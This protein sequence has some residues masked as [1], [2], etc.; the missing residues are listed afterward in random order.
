MSQYANTQ[1]LPHE[2]SP[3]QQ[4]P[5]TKQI[6]LPH[7]S[8][9]QLLCSLHASLDLKTVIRHFAQSVKQHL[10]C[11]CVYYANDEIVKVIQ[12]GTVRHYR[13]SY[14][15]SLDKQS[16]GEITFSRD[17]K[18]TDSEINCIEELL[19]HL[20]HALSNALEHLTALDAAQSDPLTGLAN[21]AA[22]IPSV[23]REISLSNRHSTP[24]SLLALDL[25]HFKIINDT[26]GHPGGDA[27]LKAFSEC[28][29]ATARASD[30]IFRSG[31]EEFIIVLS[32]TTKAGALLLAERLRR[33]VE[34]LSV[35]SGKDSFKTS[36]SIGVA[37]YTTDDTPSQLMERADKALYRAKHDGRNRISL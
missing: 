2:H 18:F 34:Q 7:D 8:T 26:Y 37:E 36:T 6:T 29:K 14:Q 10:P 1:A 11:D 32:K 28:L 20:P 16:L 17:T 4:T 5:V 23:Q 15:L 19:T 25:D 27:Y 30:I 3:E 33:T 9:I 13:C 35:T 21:R 22:L 24:L 12:L 31:G